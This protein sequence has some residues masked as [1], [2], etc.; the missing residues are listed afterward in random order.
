L[1][2]NHPKKDRFIYRNSN[3]LSLE[4]HLVSSCHRFTY[5]VHP[6]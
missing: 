2:E 6:N 5:L 1:V 3:D 4:A